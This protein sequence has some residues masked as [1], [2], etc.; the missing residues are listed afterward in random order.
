[1]SEFKC[2]ICDKEM[3]MGLISHKWLSDYM[4]LILEN[5]RAMMGAILTDPA[6]LDTMMMLKKHLQSKVICS[7]NFHSSFNRS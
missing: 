1:M 5:Q 7:K 4:L 3:R 2:P 6:G